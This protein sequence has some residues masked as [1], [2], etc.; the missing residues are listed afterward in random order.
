M[1]HA[2]HAVRQVRNQRQG[3]LQLRDGFNKRR[4]LKGSLSRFAPPFDGRFGEAACVK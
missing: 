2:R 3:L 4:A 1:L